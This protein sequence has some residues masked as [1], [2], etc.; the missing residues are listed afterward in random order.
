MYLTIGKN[1][2]NNSLNRHFK[3]TISQ[4][5][6]KSTSKFGFLFNYSNNSIHDIPKDFFQNSFKK[7]KN[8][9]N[10]NKHNEA[11]TEYNMFFHN[12]KY[13][14]EVLTNK[15]IFRT[16]FDHK[17]RF[18]D[19]LFKVNDIS[20]IKTEIFDLQNLF[21]RNHTSLKLS[22]QEIDLFIFKIR[23]VRIQIHK[24]ILKNELLL[25]NQQLKKRFIESNYEILIKRFQRLILQLQRINL[26]HMSKVKNSDNI[27]ERI[28]N[29]LEYEINSYLQVCLFKKILEYNVGEQ[30]TLDKKVLNA[31]RLKLNKRNK[32]EF[33]ELLA[34]EI[35]ILLS[36]FEFKA[37]NYYSYEIKEFY[38]SKSKI[39]SLFNKIDGLMLINENS[40]GKFIIIL[41]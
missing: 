38:Y 3:T 28:S 15:D 34:N 26:D 17:I 31:I 9:E 8:Y 40:N 4:N 18:I 6:F 12:F 32:N 10:I 24:N 33:D 16:Y 29:Q 39:L 41:L 23:D 14:I 13:K 1:L 30:M 5:L 19:N 36:S 2:F 22:K 27:E 35:N 25:C 11:I 20:K 21:I 37:Y 7:I